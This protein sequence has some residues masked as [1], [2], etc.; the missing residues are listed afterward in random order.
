M[1][2][3]DATNLKLG[4][5]AS[6]VA[7]EA[8]KGEEITVV[9]SEKAVVTGRQKDIFATY[10]FK[11]DVGSRYK[12]PFFPRQPHMIV[13][14]TIR[15][16]LPYKNTLGREAFSRVKVYIGVP[17]DLTGKE[18]ATYADAKLGVVEKRSYLTIEQISKHLGIN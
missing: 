2:I 1:K 10:E 14:R 6:H 11:R 15:G 7:K 12:G 4:R 17:R 13:R 5:M 3:V 9:N 8:L 16:M 18:T